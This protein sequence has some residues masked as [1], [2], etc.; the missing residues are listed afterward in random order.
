M[1]GRFEVVPCDLGSENDAVFKTNSQFQRGIGLGKET[2]N[3]VPS[4][5]GKTGKQRRAE[6]SAEKG[7]K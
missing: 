4:I 3:K 6:K 5:P 7:D 1:K 2:F